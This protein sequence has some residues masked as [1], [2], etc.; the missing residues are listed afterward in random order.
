MTGRPVHAARLDLG[1]A[2][3]VT[4]IARYVCSCLGVG[5]SWSPMS[6]GRSVG[7]EGMR[8]GG[9]SCVSCCVSVI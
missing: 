2:V 9:L 7:N 8:F 3:T 4:S 5:I 1:V 6:A